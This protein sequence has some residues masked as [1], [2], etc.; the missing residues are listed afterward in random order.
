MAFYN[1]RPKKSFKSIA[2]FETWWVFRKEYG[3]T[4]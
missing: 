3:Y 1:L 4:L 2:D